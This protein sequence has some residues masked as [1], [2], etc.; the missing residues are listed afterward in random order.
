VTAIGPSEA[1]AARR[2]VG[3]LGCCRHRS[4]VWRIRCPCRR[5]V[6]VQRGGGY[7]E[8][9]GDLRHA[10]IGIGE[11]CPLRRSATS[12]AYSLG[13]GKPRAGPLTDEAALELRQG[14]EHMKHQQPL[15]GR[16]VDGLGQAAKP[17]PS[18][19]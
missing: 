8:A 17:D 11:Q 15:R 13:G 4:T 1:E 16:G 2:G 9:V 19:A 18:Q 7:P 14:A 5:N 10:N 12:A 6:P 3:F